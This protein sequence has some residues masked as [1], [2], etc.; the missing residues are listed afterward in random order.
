M[1]QEGI[2]SEIYSTQIPG[3]ATFLNIWGDIVILG[4]YS[5]ILAWMPASLTAFLRWDTDSQ[6]A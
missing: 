1:R 6:T 2:I 5:D 4:G 3:T